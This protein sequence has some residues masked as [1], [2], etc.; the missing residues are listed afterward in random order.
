M[1]ELFIYGNTQGLTKFGFDLGGIM[2]HSTEFLLR[3]KNLTMK[4]TTNAIE[5]SPRLQKQSNMVHLGKDFAAIDAAES[6]SFENL[7]LPHHGVPA[8][9]HISAV[10]SEA[11][12]HLQ[13]KGQNCDCASNYSSSDLD[14]APFHPSRQDS[15]QNLS[16][17]WDN[18]SSHYDAVPPLSLQ[19]Q[20]VVTDCHESSSGASCDLPPA[21][22][23][24]R[25]SCDP[26]PVCTIDRETV[27]SA[28]QDKKNS[29]PAKDL[30]SFAID[31]PPFLPARQVS[32]GTH[33]AM[34]SKGEGKY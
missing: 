8:V 6:E 32:V 22:P 3:R 20:L 15:S 33:F 4:S 30:P 16:E 2:P 1:T 13:I 29:L 14:F 25:V 18:N 24:R 12:G 27:Y 5:H 19:Q 31:L 7:S 17:G 10:I 26:S 21:R 11:L 9:V 34:Q 28:Y 23:V